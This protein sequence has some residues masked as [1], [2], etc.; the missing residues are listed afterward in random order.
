VGNTGREL[1]SNSSIGVYFLGVSEGIE[2]AD[3]ATNQTKEWIAGL[4]KDLK[5]SDNGM[6]SSS[7]EQPKSRHRDISNG[8]SE[9][10]TAPVLP[11]AP[12]LPEVELTFLSKVRAVG[13]NEGDKGVPL[14][15][16]SNDQDAS[17]LK[18]PAQ[19]RQNVPIVESRHN[20]GKHNPVEVPSRLWETVLSDTA[21]HKNQKDAAVAS[22][23][24]T[25]LKINSY[26]STSSSR[27]AVLTKQSRKHSI[28]PTQHYQ[29]KDI[30]TTGA[31]PMADILKLA[32]DKPKIKSRFKPKAPNRV[33][34]RT[35]EGLLSNSPSALLSSRPN[36]TSSTVEKSNVPSYLLKRSPSSPACG[37]SSVKKMRPGDSS[38]QRQ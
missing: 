2:E 16:S 17:V 30:V 34:E 24:E 26:S 14:N 38:L 21:L 32:E 6:K 12:A 28:P 20:G 1:S 27:P 33:T 11:I 18:T 25:Y 4:S 8:N 10:V 5:L 7:S 22:R 36:T 9:P 15:V 37:E 3:Q 13:E 31:I 29:H 35:A 23:S 19:E